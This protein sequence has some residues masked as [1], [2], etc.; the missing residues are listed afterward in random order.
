MATKI[1]EIL[2]NYGPMFVLKF[3]D[4]FAW[5]EIFGSGKGE[6]PDSADT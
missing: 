5:R 3:G 1:N 4:Q 2:C 6:V